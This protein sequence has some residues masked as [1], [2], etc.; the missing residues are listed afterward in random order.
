MKVLKGRKVW[1]GGGA[2]VDKTWPLGLLCCASALGLAS[3]WHR[4]ASFGPYGSTMAF[5]FEFFYFLLVL[6]LFVVAVLVAGVGWLWRKLVRKG[7]IVRGARVRSKWRW[8]CAFVVAV[9]GIPASFVAFDW[10]R[11]AL[12]RRIDVARVKEES[13]ALSKM[14]R[15]VLEGLALPQDGAKLLRDGGVML[16]TYAPAFDRVPEYI[17]SVEPNFVVVTGECVVIALHGGLRNNEGL[18]IALGP[19]KPGVVE[20][21]ASKRGIWLLDAQRGIFRYKHEGLFALWAIRD[22]QNGT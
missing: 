13:V 7:V 22:C 8:Y 14:L 15:P 6:L 4:G 5:A 21:V 2:W 20:C 1:A 10:G 16:W 19:V 9:G 12:Y 3:A 11:D 18:L 17:A